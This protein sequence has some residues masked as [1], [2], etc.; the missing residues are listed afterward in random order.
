MQSRGR[1]QLHD[2]RLA[3]ETRVD[4][5]FSAACAEQLCEQGYAVTGPLLSADECRALRAGYAEE[6]AFR[7][8]VVMA[9]H[10]FGRGEYRYYCDPLPPQ[11]AAL[12]DAL[13]RKL[14]PIAN[15]WWER[16]GKRERFPAELPDYLARC[17]DNGQ[18]LP[19]PLLLRYGPGDYNC[20]HQ[21]LYGELWFPLQ[22]ALLLDEPGRD[23]EGGEFVLVEQRPRMQSRPIVVPL[24]RGECVLF[25]CNERPRAGVRGYHRSMMRHGVSELRSGERYTLGVIFH[26]ARS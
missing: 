26:D 22:A 23:F 1:V 6:H 19:T 11:V 18:G 15:R 2:D 5:R 25:A 14:A 10:G 24:R 13:Y 7:K 16:L 3:L 9:R 4:E 8:T 17:H 20:L 12:R 21:D